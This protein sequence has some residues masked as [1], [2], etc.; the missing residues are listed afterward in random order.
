MELMMENTT[1]CYLLEHL[2]PRKPAVG[3]G[4]LVKQG[5]G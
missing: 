3:G 1:L 4:S 2:V 5:K